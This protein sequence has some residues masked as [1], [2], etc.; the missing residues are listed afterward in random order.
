VND[1]RAPEHKETLNR[2]L[3]WWDAIVNER[4]E[5]GDKVFTITSEFGPQLYMP[6]L[7]YTR[8]A[9]SNQW[10][11]NKYMMNLL[12]QRYNAD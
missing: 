11:I 9:V 8:Q 12:K 6:L 10:E 2:H 7:P 4:K 1:P 3:E 5:R